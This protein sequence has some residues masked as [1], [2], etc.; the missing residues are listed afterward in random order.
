MDRAG[1]LAQFITEERLNDI[2]NEFYVEV[3]KA[4]FDKWYRANGIRKPRLQE[5]RHGGYVKTDSEGNRHYMML[6]RSKY[7]GRMVG[8]RKK[9]FS[10][11]R[12]SMSSAVRRANRLMYLGRRGNVRIERGTGDVIV[13]LN[14]D[15]LPAE[16]KGVYVDH[17][18]D[19]EWERR[20]ILKDGKMSELDRLIIR[21]IYR[22]GQSQ[23]VLFDIESIYGE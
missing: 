18:G 14:Y 20:Y 1:I 8:K 15:R 10:P 4:T 11:D 19:T 17:S 3:T 9:R 12:G 2:E 13:Y 6:R 22:W 23:G 5:G 7:T 21:A 16:H